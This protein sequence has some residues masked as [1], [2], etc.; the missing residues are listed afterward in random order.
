MHTA[1]AAADDVF[2]STD[3]PADT[4]GRTM[5]LTGG[6]MLTLADDLHADDRRDADV[7]RAMKD[8]K[9]PVAAELPLAM[10]TA[11]RPSRGGSIV[12][13]GLRRIAAIGQHP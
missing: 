1:S 11:H 10:P 13:A 5:R 2:T 6:S 3:R 8:S 4:E 12:L 9:S 7:R